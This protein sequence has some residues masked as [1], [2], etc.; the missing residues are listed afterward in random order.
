MSSFQLG[1][2]PIEQI[3]DLH[4]LEARLGMAVSSVP[5]PMRLLVFSRAF[6]MTPPITRT[7]QRQHTLERLALM[8][9]PVRA[10]LQARLAGTTSTDPGIA[11]RALPADISATLLDLLAHDPPMQQVLLTADHTTHADAPVLWAALNEA[12][13]T[14]LQALTWRIPLAHAMTHFYRQLQQRQ[15]RTVTFVMHAWE[16]PTMSPQTIATALQAALGRRVTQLD[17]LPSVLPGSYQEQAHRLMPDEPGHPYLAGLLAYEVRGRWDATTLHDL[18]DDSCDVALAIDIHTY[19]RHTATRIAEL[20][21]N[22]ARVVARDHQVLDLRAHRVM[23]AATQILQHLVDQSLH[24]VQL[25]V[26]VSGTTVEQLDTNLASIATRL[27]S[28]IRFLRPPNGQR[29]LLKLW[30]GTPR[31]RIT[32]PVKPHTMLSQG[33]GCC[34]GILGSHRPSRTDG[35]FWGIAYPGGGPL[36]F[37]LFR[38]RQAA[39]TVVMGKS[40]F[41]KSFFLNILTMRSALEGYRVIGIDAFHNAQRIAAAT[42]GGT[43]CYALSLEDTYNPLD[44]LFTDEHWLPNQVAQAQ[45]MLALILGRTISSAQGQTSQFL[46]RIFSEDEA[47]LLDHALTQLY[48]PLHPDL[49]RTEMPLLSDLVTILAGMGEP[50]SAALARSLRLLI[51]ETSRGQRFNGHTTVDWRFDADISYYDLSAIPPTSRVLASL[52]FLDGVLHFMRDP[53]RDLSRPT[54]LLID[55]FGYLARIEAFARVA[56]EISKVARKYSLGLVAVD[57]SPQIFLESPEGKD[58]F[59]N[60]RARVLFRMDAPAQARIHEAIPELRP[61]HLDYLAHAEPGHAVVVVDN[62]VYCMYVQPNAH[63]AMTLG[64]S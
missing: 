43:R 34:L 37:D 33:V 56:A 45:R 17:H 11:L 26:L 53:Q 50:E 54:L 30:S 41:G 28:Q 27:G 47:S 19:P 4:A 40:G 2:F 55:E 42:G 22:A 52:L 15:L 20:A 60:A 29:E 6:D 44:I 63:E 64:N 49:P 5:V 51:T 8:V 48:R 31:Q 13:G 14:I 18:L 21:Y 23:D 62:D 35:I 24:A 39:H 12:L 58:I 3:P 16:P 25:A 7:I 61:M 32:L 1:S 10:A 38:N 59:D 36:F 46:P 9:T 57:Q